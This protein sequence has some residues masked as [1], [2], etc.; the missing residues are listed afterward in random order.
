MS[1]VLK[2]LN[3]FM[4]TEAN[5][6][7]AYHPQANGQT[8]RV[9]A[10]V[11]RMLA[12]YIDEFHSNWNELLPLVTFAYNSA[13]QDTI[14][15]SPFELLYGRK[16]LLP[17]DI[18]LAG[19]EHTD[20]DPVVTD[21]YIR[22]MKREWKR[23]RELATTAIGERQTQMKSSYDMARQDISYAPGDAVLLRD[24]T[25]APGLS[26]KLTAKWIGPYFVEKKISDL[27]Y[28][29]TPV[30]GRKKKETVSV[31]RLKPFIIRPDET[32]SDD[33]T[34][35][36]RVIGTTLTPPDDDPDSEPMQ[37]LLKSSAFDDEATGSE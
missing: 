24:T 1:Q 32:D 19:L 33:E 37:V 10:V 29:I 4:N 15:M 34:P 21:S 25:T 20:G 11:K 13:K 3:S 30:F 9:N 27:V 2:E 8:E 28:E 35:P 7:T 36:S 31:Q 23:L 26:R 12:A 6:T 14:K 16:P 18:M 17:Q 22:L 5:H